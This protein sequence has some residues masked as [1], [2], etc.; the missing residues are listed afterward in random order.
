MYEL[1]DRWIETRKAWLTRQGVDND[2]DA[3]RL[4]EVEELEAWVQSL[5]EQDNFI[6]AMAGIPT[7]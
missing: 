5:G 6:R 3:G 7:V 2:F 4:S 1:F